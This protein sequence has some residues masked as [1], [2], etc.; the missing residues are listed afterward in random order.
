MQNAPFKSAGDISAQPRKAQ[1][2]S[3]LYSAIRLSV[4]GMGVFLLACVHGERVHNIDI[5]SRT[6]ISGSINGTAF[7]GRVSAILNTG[8]GG[9]S[10]CE[11][12]RLPPNFT[13]GTCAT[14][15]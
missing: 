2:K 6:V 8:R 12:A 13:P 1:L 7:E 14:Q 5:V 9:R 3:L 10:T 4:L 11:F 15:T